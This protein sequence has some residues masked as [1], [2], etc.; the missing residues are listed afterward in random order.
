[1]ECMTQKI[2]GWMCRGIAGSVLG[3]LLLAPAL[4]A[5][6]VGPNELAAR[7]SE[8]DG[9]V[10]VLVAGEPVADQALVNLPVSVGTEIVTGADGR[11]EIEFED[12]TVA[13]LAPNSALQIVELR[14]AAGQSLLFERGLGYFE[15]QGG[16]AAVRF[17]EALVSINQGVLVRIRL[18][19][20]PGEMAVLSGE[21]RVRLDKGARF[22][23]QSGQSATLS[24]EDPNQY[25]LT[26]L[27]ADTWDAWNS[28]RDQNQA[29][30]SAA[31][32]GATAQEGSSPAWSDLDANGSWYDVPGT[33]RI[34]SPTVASAGDWEP[35]GCGHWVWT[36]RFGYVWVSC[37]QWGF[38][39]YMCGGWDF[40]DGF[41]WGWSPNGCGM[42]WGGGY[43]ATVRIRRGPPGYRPILPPRWDPRR[44]IGGPRQ[45]HPPII[46]IDRRG[47][48]HGPWPVRGREVGIGGSTLRPLPPSHPTPTGPQR[49]DTHPVDINHPGPKPIVVPG[50]LDNG[51][52]QPRRPAVTDPPRDQRPA[53]DMAQPQRHSFW[54]NITRDHPQPTNA[55]QQSGR[56]ADARGAQSAPPQNG[57]RTALPNGGNGARPAP[58]PAGGNAPRFSAPGNGGAAPH[59]SAP[60]PPHMSAPPAPPAPHALAPAPAPAPA[61]SSTHK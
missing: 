2:A 49:N 4:R 43:F 20:P 5:A 51:A 48:G 14:G 16:K 35:Y 45:P 56:P 13:R 30:Q 24:A 50:L 12:G 58:T 21:A 60:P 37:W 33:G 41:G 18:D 39:P 28:D 59:F 55:P 29:N 52:P 7:L 8:V 26:A 36:P 10:S 23:V 11:A 3:A 54:Q 32:T 34:W 31:A 6:D 40:Y 46:P 1:M 38:M 15:T 19:T 42:G 61:A 44:P 57:G 53:N 27:T 17:G 22:K 47:P 25:N 9:Q